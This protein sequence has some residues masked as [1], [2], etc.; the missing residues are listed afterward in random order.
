MS[1]R[2]VREWALGWCEP[3]RV[4]EVTGVECRWRAAAGTAAARFVGAV[5]GPGERWLVWS[6]NRMAVLLVGQDW[7]ERRWS[8]AVPAWR[9]GVLLVWPDGAEVRLPEGLGEGLDG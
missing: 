2:L 3:V 7:V 5:H 8:G 9:D 6:A 1:E 4:A